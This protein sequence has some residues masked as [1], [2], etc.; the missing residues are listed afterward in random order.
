MY[1]LNVFRLIF[2]LLITLYNFHVGSATICCTPDQWEGRIFLDDAQIAFFIHAN[3]SADVTY[4]YTNSR[5]FINAS[6]VQRSLYITPHIQREH[7][8]YIE[9]YKNVSNPWQIWGAHK[10]LHESETIPDKIQ[11]DWNSSLA[12]KAIFESIQVLFI[13]H[14]EKETWIQINCSNHSTSHFVEKKIISMFCFKMF[15]GSSLKQSD[16]ELCAGTH[17]TIVAQIN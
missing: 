2:I 15:H 17:V 6:Y 4:D 9:D 12:V 1:F 3:I 13:F 14:Y 8:M 16:M 10:S 11:V 5:A 7:V